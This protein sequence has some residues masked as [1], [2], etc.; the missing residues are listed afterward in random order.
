VSLSRET[1]LHCGRAAA[2]GSEKKRTNQ[3]SRRVA[4]MDAEIEGT[5]GLNVLYTPPKGE[6]TIEYDF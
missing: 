5:L 1:Y 4:S 3:S 2:K 6:A